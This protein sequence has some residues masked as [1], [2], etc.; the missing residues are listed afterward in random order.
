L[1]GVTE[2]SND[3]SLC[4]AALHNLAER[5]QSSGPDARV[6]RS[7]EALRKALL[8]LIDRKPLEQITIR[9]IAAEAGVHFATFYRHY[10]TKEALLDDV[11]T[12]EISRLM[13]MSITIVDRTDSHAAV[14]ALFIDVRNRR[15]LWTSL[16]TGGA[17]GT[18]REEM[19][20]IS[21]ALS[22]ERPPKENW[23]PV[24]LAI[25]CQVSLIFEV[26]AWWLAHPPGAVPPEQAATML[27]S[28]LTSVQR[29]D[30]N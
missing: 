5:S 24:E 30:D 21:R 11:A 3:V 22:V 29:I 28:L 15:T 27:H 4:D 25:N 13:T 23:L 9:E 12:A 16:L 1:K 10:S 26:L 18:M 2:G 6:K 20:R 14:L 17:A 19:L 7:G 8:T